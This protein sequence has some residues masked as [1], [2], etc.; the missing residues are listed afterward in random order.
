MQHCNTLRQRHIIRSN[1]C[2]DDIAALVFVEFLLNL[3]APRKYR[4]QLVMTSHNLVDFRS[5]PLWSLL[6]TLLRQVRAA[7]F[8]DNF[9]FKHKIN[10]FCNMQDYVLVIILQ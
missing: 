7:L 8:V 5:V 4:R 3:R 6:R 10:V 2:S 1:Y 9:I